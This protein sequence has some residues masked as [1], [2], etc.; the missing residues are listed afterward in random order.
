MKF[1]RNLLAALA[2]LFIFS[3]ASF[4][5]FVA[6]LAGLESESPFEVEASSILHLKLDRS[7][8]ER[9]VEDP[10][11]NYSFGGGSSIGI[12]DL[13]NAVDHAA[14]DE[15]ISGIFLNISWFMG[16]FAQAQELRT[17]LNEFKATGKFIVASATRMSEGSYYVSSVADS[18]FMHPEGDL[19]FNG[20]AYSSSF[21][22]GTL[23]KLGIEAQVFKVGDYKSA[24]EPF[25]RK[26]MS[27]ENREQVS[28]FLNSIYDQLIRD[29]SM[30]RGLSFTEMKEIS[31]SMK[32]RKIDD[33]YD[34]GLIDGLKYSDQV[35]EVLSEL[36]GKEGKPT[37]VSF[38]NYRR[39]YSNSN[40]S[41]NR[42]A[43][44]VASGEIVSGNGN[45]SMIGAEK[46]VKEIRKARKSNRVKAIVLRINSPGGDFL[47]SDE[48][49]REVY[50]AR[51]EKPVIASMSSYAASG[52]YYMAMAA[53][54][55]VANP[56][57]ITGSIG[58]FSII[59]N[60]S[61][62][63]EDKLG[64]T[65]DVVKTGELSN[66]IRSDSPLTEYEKSIFQKGA[67]R[68]YNTFITKAAEGRGMKPE[69]IDAIASGRVWTGAQAQE[70]GL[71]DVLG[72]FKDAVSIAAEK[73][74]IEDDYGI[75]FYPAQKSFW[76]QVMSD[77]GMS[78]QM[79]ITKLQSGELYP[80]LQLI[81][82]VKLYQGVQARMAWE[83]EFS[84]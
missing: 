17:S 20:I 35:D 56:N 81:E 49:W 1:L 26:D 31:Q 25:V 19:E 24:I 52:G 12:L 6:I 60:M 62:F 75:R 54:T 47:A 11:E 2:A 16:G 59:F 30:S 83:G 13:V 36:S 3:I 29:M 8:S 34:L 15:N 39:S 79:K 44:I 46:F 84:F 64:I 77:V 42:I 22:K 41:K 23:D 32:V 72:T 76:E 67:E 53:D 37:L 45:S 68:G 66:L 51:K 43:V 69:E 63:M 57:T 28:S 61:T 55:I 27:A 65:S 4:F 80:Y 33:A 70:I 21:F 14:K 18:I 10:L 82:K 73:A 40:G 78:A 5:L 48:L 58:I 74:G 9:S 38:R 50:L 7:I 71:V